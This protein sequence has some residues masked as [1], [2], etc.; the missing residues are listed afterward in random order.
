MKFKKIKPITPSQRTLIQIINKKLK[1]K[2]ILKNKLKGLTNSNGRNNSGKITVRHKGKGHKKKYRI[3]NFNRKNTSIGIILS[4]EYDPNRNSHIASV[5]DINDKNFFYIIAPKSLKIGDIVKSN[6]K[7]IKLGNSLKIS[8]IPVG[9][10]VHNI[11]LHSF[12]Q[13]IFSRSAGT[14]STIKEKK[15]NYAIIQISSGKEITIPLNCHATIGMVSNELFFLSTIGKAGR[16]RWLN[17]RPTV[18]G[19]AMNP[20]DHPNGGGE[21]KKSGKTKT[22]WGKKMKK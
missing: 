20:V 4:I 22:P 2:P 11:C 7:E 18:R 5:F 12:K 6:T 15:N 8:N 16:S 9:C 13:S 21:G 14:F 3:I 1:K 19:V 10:L 17:V